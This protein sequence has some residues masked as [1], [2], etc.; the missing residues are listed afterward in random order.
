MGANIVDFMRCGLAMKQGEILV[1]DTANEIAFVQGELS[2]D[3]KDYFDQNSTQM[4]EC[5]CRSGSGPNGSLK[6]A[7]LGKRKQCSQGR[8]NADRSCNWFWCLLESVFETTRFD[9]GTDPKRI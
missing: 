4:I 1:C 8:F 3:N 7:L 6:E 2:E 9:Q 5:K